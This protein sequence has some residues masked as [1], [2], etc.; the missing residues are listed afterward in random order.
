MCLT[1]WKVKEFPPK[2]ALTGTTLGLDCKTMFAWHTS[3]IHWQ[4]FWQCADAECVLFPCLVCTRILQE[5]RIYWAD[6]CHIKIILLWS[7]I[8]R[9]FNFSK[10]KCIFRT[11]KSAEGTSGHPIIPSKAKPCT[12]EY[13]VVCNHS[14]S[15]EL[16]EPCS[17]WIP[18]ASQNVLFDTQTMWLN[19]NY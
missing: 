5:S 16:L 6:G 11:K 4:L 1:L 12:T 3:S 2:F 17:N 10:R 7:F 8:E 19:S 18:G 14:A 9:H 13:F 15:F